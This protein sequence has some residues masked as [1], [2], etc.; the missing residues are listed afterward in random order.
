MA[1][2]LF[3]VEVSTTKNT[4]YSNEN[5]R[6]MVKLEDIEPSTLK[7]KKMNSDSNVK[8]FKKKFKMDNVSVKN[9]DIK[10]VVCKYL[11]KWK[12]KQY[13]STWEKDDKSNYISIYYDGDKPEDVTPYDFV[14]CLCT[15][16]QQDK[17]RLLRYIETSKYSQ[18][19]LN[20]FFINPYH[21]EYIKDSEVNIMTL[22]NTMHF[23]IL[24]NIIPENKGF[25]KYLHK[26]SE[27]TTEV[28]ALMWF[29]NTNDD[30]ATKYS[31]IINTNELD[32]NKRKI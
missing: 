8:S 16:N 19:L 4:F 12:P 10:Q 32:R 20:N 23:E 11:N 13:Y 21:W 24:F 3:G 2:N 26:R 25:I 15:K 9:K 27:Y 18:F 6:F 31:R 7:L 28:S 5:D 29:F 14:R 1:K 22:T 30:L 17:V